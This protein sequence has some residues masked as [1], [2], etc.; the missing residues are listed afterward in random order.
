L[1]DFYKKNRERFAEKMEAGSVLVLFAGYAPVKRGDEFYPF[2]PQRNFYYLTGLTAPN[3]VLVI[4]KNLEDKVTE[5]VYLERQ[6]ELA[7]KWTGKRLDADEAKAVSGIEV[8]KYTDEL[9]A[10]VAAMFVRGSITRLYADMENRSFTMPVTPD[11]E[12]V[13][14]VRTK[15]VYIETVNAYPIFAK[16]R[17]VKTE[18]EVEAL[19]KAIAVTNEAFKA[20]MASVRDG[21]Y[22]YGLEAE[23]DYTVKKSGMDR[24]FQTI[25]ASGKNAA[26]LHY[27]ENNSVMKNGDLVLLDFGAANGW[28]SADVSRTFPVNGRFNTR[29]RQL[30]DIVLRGN[31]YI[32]SQIKPGLPFRRLNEMML[33]FYYEELRKIGLVREKEEIANYYYHGVSHMLGLETHDIGRG[34]ETELEAGMVFT[35]EPGLYVLDEGIGIRIEDDVLVTDDGCEVLTKEIMKDAEEIEGFFRNRHVSAD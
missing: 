15:F 19:R 14:L 16:L 2:A 10:N 20:M 12:F 34:S 5:S 27:H 35:V 33:E 24:A 1:C 28:Y 9:Y 18:V 8:Y 26:C 31:E 29:Q 25:V 22:E 13:N 21:M 17:A 11:I 6:D 7:T 4:A 3:L 32:I 30:Y 23:F